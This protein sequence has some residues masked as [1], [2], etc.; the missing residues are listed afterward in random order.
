MVAPSAGG[1]PLGGV[2]IRPDGTVTGWPAGGESGAWQPGQR[3]TVALALRGGR[4]TT[5]CGQALVGTPRTTKD[6]VGALLLAKPP[7]DDPVPLRLW[8]IS[9]RPEGE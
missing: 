9:I 5:G 7:G 2:V 8:R 6:R 3:F 4:L 1:S